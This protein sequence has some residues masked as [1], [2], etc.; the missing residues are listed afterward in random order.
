M[1]AAIVL[2]AGASRRLGEPKQLLRLRGCPLLS[3]VVGAVRDYAPDK[4]VVVLGYQATAIAASVDLSDVETVI[5]ERFA[6][7][8]S[9]SL[10]AGIGALRQ[11]YEYAILAT[12]DQ[13]FLSAS[14]LRSL[15]AEFRSTGKPIVATA[16]QDYAGV[17]LLLGKEAWS[18][19]DDLRGDQGARPL[20]H[21]H[22]ELVSTVPCIDEYMAIDVDTAE[23]FDRAQAV[24]ASFA[25]NVI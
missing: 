10:Q 17:P 19:V 8:M 7:G 25:A 9:T 24:A 15:E 1:N 16:Y 5:N 21:S 3:W 13:P 14:H 20:L 12:G 18:L 4:I 6:E 2:A 11:N 23:T 22:A